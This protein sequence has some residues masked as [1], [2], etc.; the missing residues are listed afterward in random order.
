VT[1]VIVERAATA[2][3]NAA[4]IAADEGRDEAGK[5]RKTVTAPVQEEQGD[6]DLF[7]RAA[8]SALDVNRPR[9]RNPAVATKNTGG[10]NGE[11]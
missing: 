10:A 1:P 2:G 9:D 8:G 3:A 11:W 5:G 7:E 4:D 6:A